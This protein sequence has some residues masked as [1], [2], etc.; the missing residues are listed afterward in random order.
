MVSLFTFVPTDLA[1]QVAHRKLEYDASLPE[2]TSLSVN[3]ITALLSLCLDATFLSFRRNVYKQVVVANLVM[4]DIEEKAL[5]TFTPHHTF[6]SGML[7]THAHFSLQ[8]RS[9]P[10]LTI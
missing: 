6:G 9:S 8:T 3:D 10:S 5:S 7:M 1:I 2:R 4:E